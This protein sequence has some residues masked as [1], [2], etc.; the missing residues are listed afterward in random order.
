MSSITQICAL[1]EE[2][3]GPSE[4]KAKHQPLDELVLT[5]LSQNTSSANCSRAF[6]NLRG[7]FGSWE[8]VRQADVASVEDA[9]R[10]GGLAKIKAGRIK[11]ALDEIAAQRGELSLDFLAEMPDEDARNCLMQF[12]GV[13]I[14]TAS[15]VLMFSLNRPVLPVDTHVHRV[16]WRLGLIERAESA[17]SAH[18]T[19]QAMIP[20]E[21]VYSFH[22]NMVAHGRNIC[23]SR[24]PV[25]DDC[26]LLPLCPHGQLLLAAGGV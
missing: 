2:R 5:V 21:L 19:L 11:R 12:D 4:S 22:V 9:I 24:S 10:V 3:Y 7:R 6:A 26:V 1:L 17:E 8:E 13:G 15:C 14:K 23:K 18:Y 16:S 25:C 20:D